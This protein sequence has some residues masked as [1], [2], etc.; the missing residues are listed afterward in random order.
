[1]IEWHTSLPHHPRVYCSYIVV[2]GNAS[3][4]DSYYR[5]D[6]TLLLEAIGYRYWYYFSVDGTRYT[7]AYEYS[8][9]KLK[10]VFWSRN[11]NSVDQ[12]ARQMIQ[13]ATQPFGHRLI[14]DDAAQMTR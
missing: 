11:D 12:L 8:F 9:N 4:V 7:T 5:K 10:D 6:G 3:T 13:T 14:P 2:D 1:M